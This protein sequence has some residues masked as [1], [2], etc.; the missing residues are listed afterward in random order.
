MTGDLGRTGGKFPAMEGIIA[1]KRDALPDSSV[2]LDAQI[3][4]E[5]IEY[6]VLGDV[7]IFYLFWGVWL[8]GW[9]V[10]RHVC[11]WL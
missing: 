8:I 9:R 2:G 5:L 4:N 3:A 1:A 11:G 7:V 6:A 10:G